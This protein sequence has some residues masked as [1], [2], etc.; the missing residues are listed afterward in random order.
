MYPQ[1]LKAGEDNHA[2][3]EELLQQDGFLSKSDIAK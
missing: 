2:M 3:Q 1:D